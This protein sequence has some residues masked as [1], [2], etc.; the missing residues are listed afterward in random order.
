M[1]G[2]EACSGRSVQVG[3]GSLEHWGKEAMGVWAA[4]GVAEERHGGAVGSVAREEEL[5]IAEAGGG[6]G[7]IPVEGEGDREWT[8]DFAPL[9]WLGSGGA[10]RT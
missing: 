3:K 4:C 10:T 9:V 6:V 7:G 5:Y 2:V 8:V 1:E